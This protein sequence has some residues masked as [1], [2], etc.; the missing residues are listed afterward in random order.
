MKGNLTL[1]IERCHGGPQRRMKEEREGKP[2]SVMSLER[3]P[4]KGE[5]NSGENS[6]FAPRKAE[7]KTEKTKKY[8]SKAASKYLS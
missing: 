5:G 4:P 1:V 2:Q 7:S 8:L 6:R 3:V